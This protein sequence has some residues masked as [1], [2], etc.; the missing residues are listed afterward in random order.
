MPGSKNTWQHLGFFFSLTML[1]RKSWCGYFIHDLIGLAWT[2]VTMHIPYLADVPVS[3][4]TIEVDTA[5]PVISTFF[6]V[7]CRAAG[8]LHCEHRRSAI[9]RMPRIFWINSSVLWLDEI[10]RL[11]E[12]GHALHLIYLKNALQPFRQYK[13]FSK[14]CPYWEVNLLCLQC[15]RPTAQH[16]TLNQVEMTGVTMST[17]MISSFQRHQLGMVYIHRYICPSWTSLTSCKICNTWK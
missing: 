14:W 11:G 13:S 7:T 1:K 3:H 8:L 12:W 10:E 2:S 16:R 17:L 15:S 9:Q 6:Q 4:K 5:T